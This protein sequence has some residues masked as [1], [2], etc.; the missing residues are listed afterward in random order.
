ME[1]LMDPRFFE[2]DY[3]ATSEYDLQYV[4]SPFYD[5]AKAYTVSGDEA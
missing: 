3:I 2:D 1:K 4:R 5:L